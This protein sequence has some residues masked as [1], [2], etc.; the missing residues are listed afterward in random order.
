MQLD[1]KGRESFVSF[2]RFYFLWAPPYLLS[3]EQD[4]FIVF[5][6]QSGAFNFLYTSLPIDSQASDDISTTSPGTCRDDIV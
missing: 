4:W 1:M 3:H 2:R 6:H 5:Q